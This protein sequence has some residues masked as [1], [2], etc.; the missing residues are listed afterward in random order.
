[1]SASFPFF[2]ENFVLEL[3]IYIL[4]FLWLMLQVLLVIFIGLEFWTIRTE[5]LCWLVSLIITI[6]KFV[7]HHKLIPHPLF[8]QFLYVNVCRSYDFLLSF[9]PSPHEETKFE[10]DIYTFW[11]F[12]PNPVLNPV[13]SLSCKIWVGWG[14]TLWCFFLFDCLL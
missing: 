9:M 14:I 4:V 12:P 5:N 1:M 3:Y 6:G 10:W 13:I 7:R 8:F 2:C 11:T